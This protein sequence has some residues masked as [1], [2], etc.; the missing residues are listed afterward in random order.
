V[1]IIVAIVVTYLTWGAASSVM[2]GWLSG[3]WASV[4][5]GA[6]AGAAGGFVG[7]FLSSALSGGSLSDSFDSGLKGALWGGISG[8]IAGGIGYYANA[9]KNWK[10]VELAQYAAHGARGGIISLGQGD[11]FQAGFLAG[12][13][14]SYAG[15]DIILAALLGG[16][17]SKLGGGK[18]EN[19][20]ITGAIGAITSSTINGNG[21]SI[22]KSLRIVEVLS[23][24]AY[25]GVRG[26]IYDKP[27]AMWSGVR[28]A[29]TGHNNLAIKIAASIGKIGQHIIVP[30]Q[31][32]WLGA[33]IGKYNL[34]AAEQATDGSQ[35]I[36]N[37]APKTQNASA[38]HDFAGSADPWRHAK[39][40]Y[41]SWV[42][43]GTEPGLFGQVYRAAGSVVFP[44]VSAMEA[45]ASVF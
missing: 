20:A 15:N 10:Y 19:G 28:D 13:F 3:V 21:Y 18:F 14:S 32:P 40:V 4:A 17:A 22:K 6:V 31:G 2:G 35:Y 38:I 25:T 41:N 24:D 1:V 27:K 16:T 29:W 45:S 44:A 12:S 33:D 11:S 39:W 9:Y 36:S 30:T 26:L 43:P 34:S 7:G 42:G 5:T 37:S 8:A 23:V